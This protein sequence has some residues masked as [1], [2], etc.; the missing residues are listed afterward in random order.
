MMGVGDVYL[1]CRLLRDTVNPPVRWPY[2]PWIKLKP[3]VSRAQADAD[4]LPLAKQFAKEN[5][6]PYPK[7][8]HLQLQPIVG[9]FEENSGHT[10]YLLLAAVLLLLA[11]G[12]VNC[13]ILLLA[14]DEARQHE[15]AV[16]S[17]IG[18]SRWRIIRQLLVESFG[19]IVFRSSAWRRHSYWLAQLPLK[20]SPNSFPA[21]SVIRINLPV[22]AFSVGLALC[23]G[24]LFG[25]VPAL[26]LSSPDPAPQCRRAFVESPAA[27]TAADG[28]C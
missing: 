21:E 14:R 26:K 1:P 4:L 10:L 17:A 25:L 23:S 2:T 9:P 7:Q 5:P 13:S 24:I 3:D 16:R 11:I 12:C 28:I 18:A 6:H 22:L 19:C 20:P 8:F 27:A 15:L